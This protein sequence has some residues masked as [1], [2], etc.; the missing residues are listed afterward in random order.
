MADQDFLDEVISERTASNPDFPAMVEHALQRRD[1][2]RQLAAMRVS[3]GI[4]QNVVAD[5]MKTSQSSIARL[6]SGEC[7]ARLSTVERYAAALGKKIEWDL[8]DI[9]PA[10]RSARRR[11]RR[12][13]AN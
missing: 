9:H 4:S 11:S 3:L 8:R 7:D 1:L 5:R 10:S 2:L 13:A 12:L 6:E